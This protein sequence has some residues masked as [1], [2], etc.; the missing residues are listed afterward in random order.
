MDS[1]MDWEELKLNMKLASAI[2]F[3]LEFQR[4]KLHYRVGG[5]KEDLKTKAALAGWHYGRFEH[6]E[7]VSKA[8]L[9]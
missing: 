8:H 1:E 2:E 4:G 9:N 7:K 5:K 3:D 6:E